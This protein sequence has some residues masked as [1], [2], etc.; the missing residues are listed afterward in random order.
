M[1]VDAS[2]M[3]ELLLRTGKAVTVERHLLGQDSWDAPHLIDVE[4]AQVLRRFV[5]REEMTA[6]RAEVSLQVLR[7]FGL[8]RHAHLA[9]LPRVWAWRRN[10]SAYDATYVALAEMLAAP[11]ITCDARLARAVGPLV[12]IVVV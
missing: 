3:V 4:V 5:M 10:L 12:E 1:I 11:L 2:A 8:T 6:A 7:D 9:L